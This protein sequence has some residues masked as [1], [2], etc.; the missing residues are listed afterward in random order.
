MK[1]FIYAIVA[2][3]G[4]LSLSAC[5]EDSLITEPT[6]S[7]SGATLM[8]DGVKALVPLNGIYRSMYTA[9]WSTTGNIHQCFGISAYN[10]MAEVM[11]DDMI[12][13][14][15]GSGWFWFDA[16]YN[17][18]NR[19]T[20]SAWRS[21]DL[22]KA[23]YTWIANANYILAAEETMGGATDDKNYAI[24]Q[25]YAIRAYSYFMLAQSFART[26]KGHENEKGVPIYTEPTT[27]TTTGQP[28]ATVAENYA[29]IT[30][31]INKACELLKGLPQQQSAH[32]SY[33]V[34][35]GI[36]SRIA[37]VME[38]WA[39][40]EAAAE[41]AIA[42][43]GKSIAKVDEFIGLNDVTKKNVM[44]GAQVISDQTGGY[45]SLFAHMDTV[46]S[47]GMGAPKMITLSLYNKIPATDTR[48]DAW[49]P[50][51]QSY[52]I[53]SAFNPN[54]PDY[55][56]GGA[57]LQRKM[58]FSDPSQ[59][60]GDYIWMRVEEMYLNA[61]EAECRQGKDGEA[62]AHLMALMSERDPNYTCSKSGNSL[63]PL[64]S[65][66]TGSLLEEIILQRRIELWGEAGRVW[67]IKRLKQGFVRNPADGW[68]SG[69]L[70]TG[71]PTNDPEN[72]MWVLSIPQA[73]FDG[74]E[75]MT[76]DEDQ[77]PLSDK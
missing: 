54:N 6:D 64:T 44:W 57:P 48:K 41:E 22:W 70:L 34:A 62:R 63:A 67:D 56:F 16:I 35:Q 60:M 75:N 71:R 30:S 23:Y 19:F 29:Q 72:Y 4:L 20:S 3:C 68:A 36:R 26:Y 50:D 52:D 10:L 32:M 77:N 12:M 61:A 28:R 13:G 5:S 39:T 27:T 43:S 31:D 66:S 47:Y 69:A 2:I 65:E 18:K 37:L 33:A 59:W 14:A 40:A 21:Y 74:N 58:Y 38:D 51:P 1:K 73:E 49:W 17:V 42:K 25:A 53:H 15:Q 55:G 8:S 46:A 45:A 7:M 24:G 76:L 9:G 11:G